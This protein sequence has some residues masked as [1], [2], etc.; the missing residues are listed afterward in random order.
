MGIRNL[1]RYLSD[2]CSKNAIHK[3]DL[4]EFQGKTIV[5]DTSIYMYK[6][7]SQNALIEN[8]YSMITILFAYKI[9][10]VFIFDGKAPPEKRDVLKQR[11]KCKKEAEKKYNELKAELPILPEP[12]RNEII[13]EMESLKKKF[14]RIKEDDIKRVKLLMDS[15]GVLYY[16]ADGESDRLCAH[17]V[18]TGKAWACLSDDMD[19]FVYGCARVMRHFSLLKH[20]VILYDLDVILEEMTISMIGFRK[21]AV[22]SGT[23]YNINDKISFREMVSRYYEFKR[24]NDEDSDFYDWLLKSTTI[25]P[26]INSLNRICEMFCVD[27]IYSDYAIYHKPMNTELMR[28]LLKSDGFVFI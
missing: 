22:L 7:M 20:T 26:D 12:A 1:N 28:R 3:T 21:I 5:V 10:P 25:N 15:F 17:L 27:D 9:I 4:K 8:M 23:D 19:M 2:R 13:S 6:F 14:V 24:D 18:K 11:S 16:D